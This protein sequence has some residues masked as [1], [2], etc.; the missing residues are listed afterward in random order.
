MSSFNL[1]NH[2]DVSVS[3][4]EDQVEEEKGDNSSNWP[5]EHLQ[6]THIVSPNI[7]VKDYSSSINMEHNQSFTG[8]S[9]EFPS[10]DS[11]VDE[12]IQ[13]KSQNTN[14]WLI[15]YPEQ[16]P[17]LNVAPASAA[18]STKNHRKYQQSTRKD[19]SLSDVQMDDTRQKTFFLASR[20]TQTFALQKKGV[21]NFRTDEF[22]GMFKKRKMREDLPEIE[23]AKK[24]AEQHIGR[25][26]DSKFAPVLQKVAEPLFRAELLTQQ[27]DFP[28]HN[29]DDVESAASEGDDD[30][31]TIVLEDSASACSSI[32][33]LLIFTLERAS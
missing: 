30:T 17:Q 2:T 19:Q 20:R 8:S 25:L 13:R 23:I 22:L 32:G 11:V 15:G 31:C 9:N 12:D 33:F 26:Q 5:I 14:K 29:N 27:R 21:K 24:Q 4:K 3:I 7:T 6:Q 1:Q 28:D 16:Q 18:A 10:A